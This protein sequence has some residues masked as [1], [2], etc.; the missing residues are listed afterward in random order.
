MSEATQEDRQELK[1][2]TD[3]KHEITSWLNQVKQVKEISLSMLAGNRPLILQHYITR[4]CYCKC[5]YCFY[6]GGGADELTTTELLAVYTQAKELGFRGVIITGGE[7]F[8][9]E[10]LPIVLKYIKYKGLTSTLITNGNY[11]LNRWQEVEDYVDNLVISVDIADDDLENIR[12][13][14]NTFQNIVDGL[15]LVKRSGSVPIIMNSIIWQKNQDQIEELAVFARDMEIEVNF[16]PMDPYL[17]YGRKEFESREEFALESAKLSDIFS[18][19]SQ[20]KQQGYPIYN[21]QAYIDAIINYKPEFKCRYLQLF[22]QIMAN[23]DVINCA[24]WNDKMGNVRTSTLEDIIYSPHSD[25]VRRNA[26][27]CNNCNRTEVLESSLM[28]QGYLEAGKNI[29]RYL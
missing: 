11:L 26:R 27:A 23:G 25:R 3:K 8:T 16:Y 17:Q 29:L 10:D 28:Y 14:A 18:E 6:T 5:P 24:N 19:I 22:T 9:R 2:S 1:Q 12:G 4:K 21:S 20:L 7:P 13:K 15:D